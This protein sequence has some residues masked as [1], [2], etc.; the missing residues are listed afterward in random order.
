MIKENGM[1]DRSWRDQLCCNNVTFSHLR[2][3]PNDKKLSRYTMWLLENRR[4]D[5][6]TDTNDLTHPKRSLQRMES[7]ESTKVSGIVY[8]KSFH[9][10]LVLAEV[11]PVIEPTGFHDLLHCYKSTRY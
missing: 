7:I 10:L 3:D 6:D 2:H 9:A 8:K 1:Q 4:R 11:S 5:H